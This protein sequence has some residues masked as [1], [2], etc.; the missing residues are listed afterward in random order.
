VIFQS[1]VMRSAPTSPLRLKSPLLS[2]P[3]AAT[4]PCTLITQ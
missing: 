2:L 4:D 3:V 1:S